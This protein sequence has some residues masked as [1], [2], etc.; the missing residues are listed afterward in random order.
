MEEKREE[1]LGL[2]KNMAETSKE[3]EER[4]EKF[5]DFIKRKKDWI[6]YLILAFVIYIGIYIRML[7]IPKLKDV[8]T[9]TWTLGPDLDPFL[10]L[11][12]AEYIVKNGSLM[13]HDAMRSVPLGYDTAGEMKLLSYLIAWFH[14]ILSALSLSDSV[15]YSAILFPVFFFALT[16]IAF[17]LFARKVF[18]KEEKIIKNII[19][20]LAT[21][22]F[23]LVPSLLPRTIAGIPEKESVAFFFMFMA[24]YFFLEAFTSKNF[25]KSLIFGVLAGIMTGLMALVW[26]GMI[27]VFFTISTAVLIYFIL[28]KVELKEFIIYSTWLFSSFTLMIPFSTRYTPSNLI[29]SLSTNSS[30]LVFLIIGFGLLIIKYDSKFSI[31]EKTKLPKELFAL[32]VSVLIIL[33]LAIIFLGFNFVYVQ[34][35]DAVTSL[36]K[37]IETRFGLTVA[38]NKQPYFHDDWEGNFGPVFFNIP[39]YFWMFF[40]GSIVLFNYLIKNMNKREKIIL[41]SSYF[42][43]LFSLIFSKYSPNGVFN[44]TSFISISLYFIGWIIL[45]SAFFFIYF[46]RN[47]K[48]E[49]NIFESLRFSYLLYFLVLTLGIIAARSAVRLMMVFGAISP[50]VVSFL[51]VKT[52]EKY[53]KEKEEL[54]KFVLGLSALIFIV[55]GILILIGNPISFISG[56][57]FGG[58]LRSDIYIGENYAPS[59]YQWQW[60]KAMNWVRENT[61]ESAVFAHWWD[62][63]YWVQSIGERA[64][65]LDGGNSIV[66]WDYLM[67]RYVLTEPDEK[68]SLEFLYTHNATHLLIDS[69]EIGKYT[70][71][72]SIGSD[73]NYDR[74]SWIPSLFMDQSKTYESKN[75]TDYLYTGGTQL[76]ED[77][78]WK[79]NDNEIILPKKSAFIGAIILRKDNNNNYL[80]PEGIYAY[81]DKTYN[82]PLRYLYIDGKL[83]DFNS[84]LES[85]AFIFPSLSSSSDGTNVNKIGAALYLSNRTVNSRLVRLY[86]FED[87]SNYFKIVHKEENF[88]TSELR[89]QNIDVGDFVYYQGFQGPI[90]IWEISYPRDIKVNPDFL[91]TDYPNLELKLAKTGEY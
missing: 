19:A 57:G 25:K 58:Y 73:E 28:G 2:E 11:R 44:G 54:I 24:F 87:K 84:G 81:K 18:D 4:K 79:L 52:T 3:I 17:F 67:G 40:V 30:I 83:R 86:L 78:I 13:V 5:V 71:F 29:G 47:S 34:L 42:I 61:S 76:D 8:T 50:I 14:N 74:F 20:L 49:L 59:A 75:E 90:K 66:Y 23:V 69:T 38:E 77:I 36:I 6:F 53:F 68:K 12:W 16:A 33:I 1:N 32:L 55:F 43:F 41:T 37:P 48:G 72:S 89:N 62:Y 65:V 35:S 9:G 88:I 31:R 21:F 45:I 15:T 91:K 22:I 80:Q 82:I 27:F 51:I 56:K 64:T 70:A 60:Q 10:F 39:L 26:G 46:K 85:G 63:G 7:N